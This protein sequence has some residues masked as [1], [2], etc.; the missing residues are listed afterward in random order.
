MSKYLN[1]RQKVYNWFMKAGG[2]PT[3]DDGHIFAC[4]RENP[5][6]T[7]GKVAE[8]VKDFLGIRTLIIANGWIYPNIPKN[9]EAIKKAL[10][11]DVQTAEIKAREEAD[12]ILGG[13]QIEYKG[14]V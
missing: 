5:S 10:E 1:A 3:K 2:Y 14:N 7:A 8:I 11:K 4:A 13:G 12:T 6:V 9:Q